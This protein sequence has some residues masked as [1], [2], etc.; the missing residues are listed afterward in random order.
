MSVMRQSKD[1]ASIGERITAAR[2]CIQL[3]TAQLSRRLGVQTKTL[4]RWQHDI[5]QPRSNRLAMLAGVLGV[6]PQW[7]LV[8]EG[9]GPT[10][11]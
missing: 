1:T 2:T 3:S 9:E 4:S 10:R 7:L 8:G 5:S 11:T 6:S